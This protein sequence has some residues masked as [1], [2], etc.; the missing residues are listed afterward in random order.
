MKMEKRKSK[1][2]RG[3]AISSV[4]IKQTKPDAGYK[5]L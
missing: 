4:L 3:R 2:G 5:M 1:G